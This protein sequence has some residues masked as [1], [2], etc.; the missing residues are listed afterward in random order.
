MTVQ[1]VRLDDLFVAQMKC[2]DCG[3]PADYVIYHMENDLRRHILREAKRYVMHA[4][5]DAHA[6]L[7]KIERKD[8]ETP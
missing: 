1:I 8:E 2:F 5:C 7:L 4:Y 3:Q 6:P